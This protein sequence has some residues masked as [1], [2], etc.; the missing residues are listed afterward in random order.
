MKIP[1]ILVQWPHYGRGKQ[2]TWGSRCVDKLHNLSNTIRDIRT[3]GVE[4]WKKRMAKTPNGAAEKQLWYYRGCL[5][6]ISRR[7]QSP[8]LDEFG[9]AVLELCQLVGT[10][11]DIE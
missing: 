7:W 3:E 2:P 5:K 11:D 9:R 8:M 4:P 10:A 6:E 1:A